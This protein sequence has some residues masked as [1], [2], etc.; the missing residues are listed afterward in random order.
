M[1][2]KEL[3]DFF[4]NGLDRIDP[5]KPHN[6]DNVV[7]CCYDCNVAKLDRSQEDFKEWTKNIASHHLYDL[8][9]EQLDRAVK[10]WKEQK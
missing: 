1:E 8:T 5:K 9:P 6:I 2:N 4:Y 3:G 10:L 7:P